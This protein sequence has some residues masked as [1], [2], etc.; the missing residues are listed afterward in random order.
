MI[1]QVP[2]E[3]SGILEI[4]G[5]VPFL[6]IAGLA[7][8]QII[9][10]GKVFDLLSQDEL[11][12]AL[13]HERAHANSLDN[14]KHLVFLALPEILPGIHGF[15]EIEQS[16]SRFAE[17]SADDA[18]IAGDPYRGVLLAGALVRI[19]RFQQPLQ[20]QPLLS[21]IISDGSELELR[22]SHLLGQSTQTAP[23]SR[24]LEL[25]I[26]LTAASPLIFSAMLFTQPRL[27]AQ[28]FEF[29]EHSLR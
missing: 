14:L 4:P 19:A 6:A 10:S 25:V 9:A 1:R 28:A 2:G 16:W 13:Q 24:L 8:H 3:P 17:R 15:K 18:A 29:L 23:A 27:I 22:V 20:S 11:Q 21:C 7:S 5:Q 12:V 26:L